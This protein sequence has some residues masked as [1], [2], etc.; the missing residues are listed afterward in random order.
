[1]QLDVPTAEVLGPT[2]KYRAGIFGSVPTGCKAPGCCWLSLRGA[3]MA[4]KPLHPP[5]PLRVRDDLERYQDKSLGRNHAEM[6]RS[7]WII[8]Y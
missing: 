2:R 8:H 1:V 6:C 5:V 7:V 3:R 4:R